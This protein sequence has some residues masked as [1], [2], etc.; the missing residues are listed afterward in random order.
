M[1]FMNDLQLNIDILA[2]FLLLKII[3]I[4]VHSD[5]SSLVNGSA[6]DHLVETSQNTLYYKKNPRQSNLRFAKDFTSIP[7]DLFDS[8]FC[9]SEIK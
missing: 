6:N 9:N 7:I 8:V 5:I 4:L 3:D 2:L 1:S